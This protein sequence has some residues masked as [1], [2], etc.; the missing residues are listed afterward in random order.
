MIYNKEF[1]REYL[2]KVERFTQNSWI[3]NQLELEKKPN[4]WTIIEY[5][6]VGID[7]KKSSHETRYSKMLRWLLDANE[8]HNLGNIFASKLM[9]LVDDNENY[10]HSLE[11]NKLIKATNE[12]LDRI[13]IFYKDLSQ[14]MCIAVELKQYTDEHEST[15]FDS[16]L[17]KYEVAVEKFIGEKKQDITPH[18]IYL[19]PKKEEPSNENWVAV[20][21]KEII[22]II[23]EIDAEYL[24]E[25]DDTCYKIDT[26][27]I[28]LDFKYDL[29][30]T[31]DFVD[32]STEARSIRDNFS[33]E[34][35]EFTTLLVNEI[36]REIESDYIKQLKSLDNSID[37]EKI[38]PILFKYIKMQ[39]QEHTV[40]EAAGLLMRKIYNMLAVDSKVSLD[41]DERYAEKDRTAAIKP[42]YIEKY[43]LDVQEVGLTRSK[44][45]G[46]KLINTIK[47]RQIYLSSDHSGSFPNDYIHI[48]EDK[49]A[50]KPKVNGEMI[51]KKFQLDYDQVEAGRVMFARGDR[52][53]EY[54]SIEDLL[55]QYIMAEVKNLS[56]KLNDL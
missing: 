1:Q 48:S 21:Y 38:I 15:G 24:S 28:L 39:T 56:D 40:N 16:Q 42:Y 43:D 35:V 5:G 4:F 45:Q 30:R 50:G 26:K 19:T 3:K 14:N 51:N 29:Q 10:K 17:D 41:V 53:N 8:N 32:E 52:K 18:Y 27:K 25:S 31:I 20:G 23:E 34:E 11:E 9:K 46:L 47:G 7:N 33:Q 12:A 22:D 2:E 36:T 49:K 6:K 13:D 55:D 44:G 54:I 37:I